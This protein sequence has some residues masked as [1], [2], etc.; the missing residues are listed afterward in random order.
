MK[1]LLKS[2]FILLAVASMTFL[3]SCGDEEEPLPDLPTVSVTAEV[4][5]SAATS[6]FEAQVGDELSFNAST[7]TAGGFNVIRL[8][9]SSDG[10]TSF[11]QVGEATRTDLNLEAGTLAANVTLTFTIPDAFEAGDELTFQV[12]VVDD[13]NQVGTAEVVA[14]VISPDAKVQTAVMLFAPGGNGLT[15][16]FYSVEKNTLYT[17]DEVDN[18]SDPLSAD[19]DFGYYYGTEANLVSPSIFV[20]WTGLGQTVY[21]S[22]ADGL[23]AWGTRNETKLVATTITDVTE[24]STVADVEAALEG[25]DFASADAYVEAL[26]TDSPLIAFETAGGVKGLIRVVDLLEGFQVGDEPNNPEVTG[27]IT[28]EFILATAE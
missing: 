7:S 5:G 20:S 24:V 4:N 26:T 17:L 12:E 18:S 27:N 13:A 3:A 10:G 16:T 22:A 23:P 25:I 1:N 14:N 21:G 15:K 2:S 8:Y 9:I 6:P 28:L 19:I 11:S